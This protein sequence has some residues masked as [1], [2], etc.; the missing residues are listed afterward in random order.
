MGNFGLWIRK[1]DW[2]I[3]A[4]RLGRSNGKAEERVFRECRSNEDDL[5]LLLVERYTVAGFTISPHLRYRIRGLILSTAV[6]IRFHRRRI[7]PLVIGQ[8]SQ[9]YFLALR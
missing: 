5:C 4:P 3:S 7:M 9:N 6:M 1:S 2:L 8:Q